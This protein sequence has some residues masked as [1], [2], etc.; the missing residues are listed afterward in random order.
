MQHEQQ[1]LKCFKVVLY[2]QDLDYDIKY[3]EIIDL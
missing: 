2:L 1:F 3:E